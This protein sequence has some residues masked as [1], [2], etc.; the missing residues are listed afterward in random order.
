MAVTKETEF[1]SA[2]SFA[3]DVPGLEFEEIADARVDCVVLRAPEAAL[4]YVGVAVDLY[5]R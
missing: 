5:L 1:N 4:R 3:F 2:D